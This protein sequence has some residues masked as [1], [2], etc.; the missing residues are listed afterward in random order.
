MKLQLAEAKASDEIEK[1]QSQF[2]DQL[3]ILKEGLERQEEIF[4]KQ[5][6]LKRGIVAETVKLN[7]V[8]CGNKTSWEIQWQITMK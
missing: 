3:K 7:L 1:V 2:F 8:M 4:Q 6:L 5:L